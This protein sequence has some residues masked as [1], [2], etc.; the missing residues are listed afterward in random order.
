M[1]LAISNPDML[2]DFVVRQPMLAALAAAG[3][4][5]LLIVRAHTA[6]LAAWAVPNATI[7][8][9]VADPYLPGYQLDAAPDDRLVNAVT[10]FDPDIFVVASY[11]HTQLEEQLAQ[12]LP[13]A[14]V[15]GFNGELFQNDKA[16]KITHLPAINWT[17]QVQV[18]RDWLESRKNEL[19][20]GAILGT[21][22]TLPAPRLTPTKAFL[23]AA[24]R[25]LRQHGFEKRKFWIVCAGEG[26]AYTRLKNWSLEKW[27]AVCSAAVR[28]HGL[29]LVFVGTPAEHESIATIRAAM[30]E[31]AAKTIDMTATPDGLDMLVGLTALADGYLGKDSGPMH[32]AAALG[33]PVVAVFGGGHWPRFLPSSAVGRVLSVNVPCSDCNWICPYKTSYCVKNIPTE[34]VLQAVAEVA[35]GT[36]KE[37]EVSLLQP[38]PWVARAMMLDAA[39][40]GRDAMGVLEV[41][42]ANFV[43]WHDDRVRD[44]E[45]LQ[46]K[47]S[48]LDAEKNSLSTGNSLI[49]A[50]LSTFRDG[51]IDALAARKELEQTLA[52]R[53]QEI[54]HLNQQTAAIDAAHQAEAATL[55]LLL[56]QKDEEL[57]LLNERAATAVAQTEIARGQTD[58]SRKECEEAV[59]V[60][61]SQTAQLSELQTLL[62]AQQAE[63]AT[64]RLLLSQKDEELGRLNERAATAAAQTEIARSQTDASRTQYEEAFAALASRTAQLSEH[65]TLFAASQAEVTTLRESNRR[66]DLECAERAAALD[67][68]LAS[69]DQI[70]SRYQGTI[71]DL[72]RQLRRAQDQLTSVL[73]LV[74][75]LRD[76]LARSLAEIARIP[77]FKQDLAAKQTHIDE[78]T[79]TLN[80][81]EADRA[82]RLDI[83]HTLTAQ[84]AVVETDRANRGI[85]IDLLHEHIAHQQV[86]IE[87]IEASL[88]P[89][90]L[91]KLLGSS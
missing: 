65:Q 28:D 32:I 76:E 90:R 16:R 33:K 25:R 43:Q 55:R 58:A 75:N 19:L 51:A 81:V 74:A 24:A 38:E 78:L 71:A 27:A 39:E 2:G 1:R 60:L 10:A 14:K 80:A 31:L 12:R 54:A 66:L 4:E 48:A 56:S 62:A 52:I 91:M 29:L 85:Q 45:G 46:Q 88:L 69:C 35:A 13:R 72:R 44:I 57:G 41:E 64:L 34:E 15:I 23:T 79:A 8:Q 21:S 42:R 40:I 70:E 87:R 61:A 20:A 63:A 84:L 59:A 77:G 49:A 3:H 86:K 36:R 50:E 83:I 89:R 22:V 47:I 53:D 30:G 37:F 17:V 6:P 18:G 9:C 73:T 7:V 68:A 11:Q 67:A 26:S 5:M 82:D